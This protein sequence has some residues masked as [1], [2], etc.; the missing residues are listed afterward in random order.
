M[1]QA[2]QETAVRETIPDTGASHRE[3]TAMQAAH[4]LVDAYR[5]GEERGGSI[6]WDDLNL[7]YET[8]LRACGTASNQDVP[9][10][11]TACERLAI[12]LDGG[13]VQGIVTDRPDCALA[14]AVMTTMLKDS[15]MMS[16]V[17]SPKPMAR[18][19]MPW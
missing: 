18:S 16:Y 4:L 12:V 17:L 14:V 15:R 7:A 9:M 2:N 19:S 6:D 11:D 5:R 13:I 8:A 1:K 3:E 10:S